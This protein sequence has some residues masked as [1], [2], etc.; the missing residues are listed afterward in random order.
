[1][2]V[3]GIVNTPAPII[4]RN[5]ASAF[6]ATRYPAEADAVTAYQNALVFALTGRP[7]MLTKR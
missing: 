3:P 6:A 2:A 1:M 7:R 5:A 4:G